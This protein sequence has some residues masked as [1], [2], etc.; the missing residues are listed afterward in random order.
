MSQSDIKPQDEKNTPTTEQ[1]TSKSFNTPQSDEIDLK[2]IWQQFVNFLRVILKIFI[3]RGV[4]LAILLGLGGGIGFYFHKVSNPTFKT[5]MLINATETD[6][7]ILSGLLGSLQ[8]LADE[9][10]YAALADALKIK[11][12]IAQ[13]IISIKAV[14]KLVVLKDLS[15]QQN[16]EFKPGKDETQKSSK[17][18][19][20]EIFQLKDQKFAV[21]LSLTNNSNFGTL[22]NAIINYLR[23]NE[24]MKK[25]VKLK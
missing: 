7:S 14:D 13:T 9:Q 19:D 20:K 5:R 3:K 15:A 22:E 8:D 25:K 17:E 24:Y 18:R 6:Y 11:Q 23:Q 10:N 12:E 4:I 1:P 21:E 2:V 16:K